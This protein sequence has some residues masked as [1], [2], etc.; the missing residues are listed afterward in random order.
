MHAIWT[1]YKL[2]SISIIVSKK[3]FLLNCKVQNIDHRYKAKS[4]FFTFYKYFL[5]LS[6]CQF[7]M[8]ARRLRFSSYMFCFVVF[9]FPLE[10]AKLSCFL[11]ISQFN[12]IAEKKLCV[13]LCFLKN[14]NQW[15]VVRTLVYDTIKSYQVVIYE[16]L[17]EIL[18][19]TKTSLIQR[20]TFGVIL[21]VC[22]GVKIEKIPMLP[23]GKQLEKIIIV[24]RCKFLDT[25]LYNVN[26]AAH[27]MALSIKFDFWKYNRQKLG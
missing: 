15:K 13:I 1:F 9:F 3:G 12:F 26:D 22:A 21:I 11:R 23:F 20:T 4:S 7:A 2:H 24:A 19:L 10:V 6:V 14:F 18:W 17:E 16:F 5:Y 25:S 8:K 27:S